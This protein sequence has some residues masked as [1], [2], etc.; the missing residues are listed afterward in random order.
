MDKDNINFNL[1]NQKYILKV[2]FCALTKIE[3]FQIRAKKTS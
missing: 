2:R 1:E 3:N